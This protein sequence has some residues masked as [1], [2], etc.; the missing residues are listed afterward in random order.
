MKSFDNLFFC[1][2]ELMLS[3]TEEN[4]ITV[5]EK[6][7]FRFKRSFARNVEEDVATIFVW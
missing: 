5:Y 3:L 6:Q 7:R 2:D 4:S 1:P